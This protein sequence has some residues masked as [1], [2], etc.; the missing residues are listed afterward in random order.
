MLPFGRMLQY[1]NI[2]P[3]IEIV[4]VQCTMYGIFV[5]YNNGELYYRGFNGNGE[6]GSGDN[7]PK[8]TWY[9]CDVPDL[10]SKIYTGDSASIIVTRNNKVY[11]AGWGVYFNIG[12]VNNTYVDRTPLF[13][14]AGID[15]S[16]MKICFGTRGLMALSGGTLYAIG[17]GTNAGASRYGNVGLGS[18]TNRSS[19]YQVGTNVK[20]MFASCNSNSESSFYITNDGQLFSTGRNI[21][22][23]CGLGFVGEVPTF[24]KVTIPAVPR[25][26]IGSNMGFIIPCTNGE[27]YMTGSR[28]EGRLGDGTVAYVNYT[29]PT[30]NTLVDATFVNSINNTMHTFVSDYMILFSTGTPYASGADYNGEC[31]IGIKNGSYSVYTPASYVADFST[32]THRG[33]GY[34]RIMF[35]SSEIYMAGMARYYTGITSDDFLVFTKIQNPY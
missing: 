23:G 19:F 29:S 3:A 30:K 6:S 20:D 25:T 2:K 4:D 10:V 16:T 15:I 17:Q 11:H 12:T 22:G 1:G 24:T 13:E 26:I 28:G 21:N 31:A 27:L 35:N 8:Y 32:F 9:K 7:I 33:G 34:F 14:S 5:L 18:A